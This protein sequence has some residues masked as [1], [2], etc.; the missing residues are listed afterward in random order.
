MALVV[1]AVPNQRKLVTSS[2]R[3]CKLNRYE[4]FPDSAK[5][6][7]LRWVKLAKKPATRARRIEKAVA[8]AAVNKRASGTS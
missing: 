1:A 8:L 6:D 2:R 4:A 5:R 7:I 3:L